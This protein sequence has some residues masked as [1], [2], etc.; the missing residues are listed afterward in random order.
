MTPERYQ[1]ILELCEEASKRTPDGRAAF[2]AESCAGDDD[3]RS[4]VE[5]MLAA[6]RSGGFLEKPLDDLAAGALAAQEQ[7]S[8][9]G[10]PG[11][12]RLSPGPQTGP[13][14]SEA[15]LGAGGMGE[16]YRAV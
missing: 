3:L 8:R 9:L 15:Q 4:Q 6:D 2:L 16:V 7:P 1:Q 5:A 14:K 11:N 12:A 13:Y 10:H